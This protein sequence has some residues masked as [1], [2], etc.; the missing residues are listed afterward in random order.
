MP[1]ICQNGGIMEIISAEHSQGE[2]VEIWQKQWG[3]G[4][5]ILLTS[6]PLSVERGQTVVAHL[7]EALHEALL[8]TN[9]TDKNILFEALLG[10]ANAVLR[11]Q[12][13]VERKSCWQKGGLLLALLADGELNV[14]TFGQASTWLWRQQKLIEISKGLSS[15]FGKEDSFTDI[16]SGELRDNDRLLLSTIPQDKA[17]LS[18]LLQDGVS[19]VLHGLLQQNDPQIASFLKVISIKAPL[20]LP[21]TTVENNTNYLVIPLL[22]LAKLKSG[23][24]YLKKLIMPYLAN[25]K[26][27]YLL[28]AGAGLIA[29]VLL[30]SLFGGDEEK[31]TGISSELAQIEQNF[32]SNLALIDTHYLA[33]E[34]EQT[35]LLLNK[36]EADLQRLIATGTQEDRAAAANMLEAI[37]L[38]KQ[39]I[40]QIR[41]IEKPQKVIDL[42]ANGAT[43]EARGLFFLENEIYVFDENNLFKALL[44]G[45]EAIKV[46]TVLGNDKIDKGVVFP[47][48]EGAVFISKGK[49]ILE[50]KAGEQVT[51]ATT[52]DVAWKNA[53]SL[54]TYS[55]YLY[56]LDT[57]SGTIWK[58]ERQNAGFS[59]PGAWSKSDAERLKTAT[60][61]AVDGS[62][63][64]WHKDNTFTKWYRGNPQEY[65]I[66]GAPSKIVANKVFTNA[67]LTDLFLLDSKTN[68]ITILVKNE[69]NAAYSGQITLPTTDTIVDLYVLDKRLFLLTKD[70]VL[71][72]E[73]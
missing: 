6:L 17:I 54:Q 55:K 41:N 16:S 49:N 25:I 30:F 40:N 45:N 36:I 12:L 27:A 57:S 4:Q 37:T 15:V 20:T 38:K 19:E 3:K 33:G 13:G 2:F 46:G 66:T 22:L 47:S 50:W 70:A 24:N 63:F 31:K 53:D 21:F 7:T 1:E 9:T 14:S 72:V 18:D 43:K 69:T 67:D 64:S 62:I 61:L 58:Y 73:L 34:T 52:A 51:T 42:A 28:L 8:D 23:F 5:L 59:L 32:S 39:K 48:K 44:G 35:S 68:T 71:T 26:P 65:P 29:I 11:T 10:R 60:S 56:T